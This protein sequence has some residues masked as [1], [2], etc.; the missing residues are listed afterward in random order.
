MAL[1]NF[2]VVVLVAVL[3]CD[4]GLSGGSVDLEVAEG[5]QRDGVTEHVS[6]DR[7][8][9]R[10]DLVVLRVIATP[11]L[12][13]HKFT[14]STECPIFLGYRMILGPRGTET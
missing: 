9:A 4:L 6:L 5:N 13:Y 8:R 10:L 3:W 14:A 2:E 1:L 11:A 7:V 12:N